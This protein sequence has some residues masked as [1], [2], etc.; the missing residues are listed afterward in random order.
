MGQGWL[1]A[2]QEGGVE[3]PARSVALRVELNPTSLVRL[4]IVSVKTPLLVL[5]SFFLSLLVCKY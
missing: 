4:S 5:F 1:V 2:L 3:G